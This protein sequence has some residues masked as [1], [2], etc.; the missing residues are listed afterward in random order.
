MR[1]DRD[2]KAFCTFCGVVFALLSISIGSAGFQVVAF[3]TALIAAFFAA[4]REVVD[5]K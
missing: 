3:I 1:R 4:A 2:V 5:V